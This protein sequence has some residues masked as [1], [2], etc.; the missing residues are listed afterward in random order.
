MTITTKLKISNDN[1]YQEN[2]DVLTLS[3][4]TLFVD[5][6]Y[7]SAPTI[8]NL[9]Q[10]PTAGWVTGMT[11]AIDGGNGLT[12]SGDIVSL[13][14]TLTQNTS[15]EGSSANTLSFKYLTEFNIVAT[16]I[17][18]TGIVKINTTPVDGNSTSD[19]ILV[20][21][22]ADKQIKKIGPSELGED[23]NRANVSSPTGNTINLTGDEYVVFIDS[24]V[25]NVTVNLPTSP[26]IGTIIKVKDTGNANTYD[27]IID[28]GSGKVI[29]NAQTA[30]INTDYGAIEFTYGKTNI[31]YSTGFVS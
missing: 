5:I 12:R 28:S 4:S 1:V 16:N 15:V 13:G 18:T 25:G 2:G 11:S 27:I 30:T 23:N 8:T 20:W 31:W 29:D 19:S 24:S 17:N 9:L 21:N 3:G 26:V 10:I 7:L 6:A 14:G 22:S